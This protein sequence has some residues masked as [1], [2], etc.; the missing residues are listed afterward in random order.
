M[1]ISFSRNG[2]PIAHSMFQFY[3]SHFSFIH[4]FIR[5]FFDVSVYATLEENNLYLF[6]NC[7]LMNLG[8]HIH[9]CLIAMN[10]FHTKHAG[11]EL[12]SAQLLIRKPLASLV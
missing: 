11:R 4:N 12:L 2:T 7:M 10:L 8:H 1:Y 5:H 9:F 6:C 3:F